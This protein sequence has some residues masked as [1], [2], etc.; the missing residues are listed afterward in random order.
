MGSADITL[1]LLLFECSIEYAIAAGLSEESFE[2]KKMPPVIL[3]DVHTN[4]VKRLRPE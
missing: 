3:A 4:V 2:V 1:V